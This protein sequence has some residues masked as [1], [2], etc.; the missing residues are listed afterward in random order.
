LKVY[1]S[2]RISV[3]E[4]ILSDRKII[5]KK[6]FGVYGTDNKGRPLSV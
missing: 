2:R 4:F 3:E 6:Y 5:I 1:T